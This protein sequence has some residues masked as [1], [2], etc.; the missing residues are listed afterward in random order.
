LLAAIDAEEGRTASAVP[1][2]RQAIG[3]ARETNGTEGDRV[4]FSFTVLT[5]TGFGDFSAATP[6]GHARPAEL[7]LLADAIWPQSTEAGVQRFSNWLTRNGGHIALILG[8]ATGIFL[9]ARGTSPATELTRP[10]PTLDVRRN[11]R[12]EH[13]TPDD[14]IHPAISPDTGPN[15]RP[16]YPSPDSGEGSAMLFG[17]HSRH[18]DGHRLHT[19][20][21][22]TKSRTARRRHPL[23]HRRRAEVGRRS[24]RAHPG[25]DAP[26][27]PRGKRALAQGWPPGRA[28]H[29]STRASRPLHS[30]G[31]PR[32]DRRNA[33]N[34]IGR[35][36]SYNGNGRVRA[37]VVENVR[38]SA[39]GTRVASWVVDVAIPKLIPDHATVR[40]PQRSR[41]ADER[42]ERAAHRLTRHRFDA[43]RAN[44]DRDA[45]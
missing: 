17:E 18:P 16:G 12:S 28:H 8:S 34:M 13:P 44:R 21:P 11:V 26:R 29:S 36:E 30:P 42:L 31:S 38:Q 25:G 41:S 3:Y 22:V 40:L 45:L 24:R 20:L 4:Y 35:P 15:G 33:T 6:V 27:A 37:T 1:W 43:A 19:E 23:L 5:T 9:L 32:R 2:G 39:L 7:P 10:E 14:P